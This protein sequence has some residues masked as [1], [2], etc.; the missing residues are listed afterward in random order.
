MS[1]LLAHGGISI[2][3]VGLFDWEGILSNVLIAVLLL[4]GEFPCAT[5][6][7]GWL[8]IPAILCIVLSDQWASHVMNIR[9]AG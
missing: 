1:W 5:F 4:Y 2:G 7:D 3:N 9:D 8:A 6:G